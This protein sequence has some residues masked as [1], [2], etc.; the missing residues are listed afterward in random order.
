[1][2]KNLILSA[3]NRERVKELLDSYSAAKRLLDRVTKGRAR[4]SDMIT[5]SVDD[6]RK[7]ASYGMALV[8]G[9]SHGAARA[10]LI[11]EIGAIKRELDKLNISVK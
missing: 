2:T 4:S 8:A 3:A 11:F 5:I 7:G 10:A 1:M 6:Q 9:L